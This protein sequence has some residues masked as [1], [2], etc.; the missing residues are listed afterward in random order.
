MQKSKRNDPTHRLSVILERI[1]VRTSGD[2]LGP[3]EFYFLT[4]TQRTST[5]GTIQRHRIPAEGHHVLRAGD[6]ITPDQMI[7]RAEVTATDWIVVE[8]AAWEEDLLVDDRIGTYRRE[9]RG[10]VTDWAGAYGPAEQGRSPE[11]MKNWML[12]YRIEVDRLD[13]EPAV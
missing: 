8:V 4:T 13:P 3:G 12:W 9:F 2:L 5:T 7:F 10:A 1:E 11:S 6:A